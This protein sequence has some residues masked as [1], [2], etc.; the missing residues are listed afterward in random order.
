MDAGN[1]FL[2]ASDVALTELR[3]AAG[4]GIRY[5]SPLGPLRFD[6]GFK[7]DRR[8]FSRGNR[9]PGRL[10]PLPGAGVLMARRGAAVVPVAAAVVLVLAGARLALADTWTAVHD[11]ARAPA[12]AAEALLE[13]TLAIVGGAVVTQSD[14]ALTQALG[15]V[16]G[17]AASTPE[18]TLAALVDRWL[19]LHE[20]ARFA[21]AEPTTAAVEARLAVVQARMGDAAAVAR[22]L[23]EGGRGPSYLAAWVRDD[24]RIAAYLEQRFA[25]AGAP[26]ESDVT[27]Y[28]EAHAAELAAAGI[29]GAA[30]LTTARER[31]VQDRRRELIADWLVDLRRR[32]PVVTFTARPQ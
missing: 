10:S 25:S 4:F 18:A 6:I 17:S 3:T 11:Q 19:M 28:A 27:A 26:A 21:P 2:R 23:A 12:P 9:T 15:L 29:T 7:L 20:V 22:R 24:L 30:V 14:V 13:R 16:E 31:L 5:R 32:T 1:V 8:D